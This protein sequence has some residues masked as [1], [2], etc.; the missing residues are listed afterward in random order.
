MKTIKKEELELTRRNVTASEFLAY[1]RRQIRSH[2]LTAI[3]ADDIDIDYFAAGNDLNFDIRYDSPENGPCAH[4]RSISRPYEMQTYIRNWDGTVYNCICEFDFWDDKTGFGYFYFLNEWE[5]QEEQE[6]QGGS[7]DAP[8]LPATHNFAVAAWSGS[9]AEVSASPAPAPVDRAERIASR[10]AEYV[11]EYDA[12]PVS[13]LSVCIAP[14]NSK[15]GRIPNVSMPPILSCRGVCWQ[16]GKHCYD[17]K[18][19]LQYTGT[20]KAR[21]R[22]WSI[23]LRDPAGYFRQIVE[24][25]RKH[26]PEFFRYHSGGEIPNGAYLLR[27]VQAARECPD[28]H[29]LAFTK[30]HR[31][32]SDYLDSLA[33]HGETLPANLQIIL[34][35]WP[36]M[37]VYNPHGLPVSSPYPC[38][39]PD[40]WQECPGNC[41]QCCR[42]GVGCWFLSSGD[43]VGFRYHGTDS[44]GFAETWAAWED[45]PEAMTDERRTA[46]REEAMEA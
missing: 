21:A 43:V 45:R 34:S 41:E 23:W 6:E 17:G 39:R 24:Y 22:N 33:D 27:M 28:T 35:A 2:G 3:S 36:G 44:A 4:E 13:S 26:S 15:T 40:G 8:A 32:V 38:D 31:L 19:V 29:F 37:P 20:A 7:G 10:I 11:A 46:E 12:M 9:P 30:R 25:C 18:A 5:E 16:C 14:G 1:V 42:D